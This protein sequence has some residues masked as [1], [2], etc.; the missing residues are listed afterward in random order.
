MMRKFLAD[1]WY[2]RNRGYGFRKSLEL[3]RRSI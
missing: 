2:W 1:F 3:A